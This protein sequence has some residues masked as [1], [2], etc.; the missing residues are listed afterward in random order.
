MQTIGQR[1]DCEVIGQLAGGLLD[2]STATASFT[3]WYTMFFICKQ[4]MYRVHKTAAVSHVN[5]IMNSLHTVGHE[6][7]TIMLI[8]K[9]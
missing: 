3:A 1:S 9:I 4:N 2:S 7:G 5:E 8:F 6:K